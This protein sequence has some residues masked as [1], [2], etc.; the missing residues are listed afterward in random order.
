[1]ATKKAKLRYKI[2]G[3]AKEKYKNLIYETYIKSGFFRD[4]S[5]KIANGWTITTKNNGKI[6]VKLNFEDYTLESPFT[7]NE[8]NKN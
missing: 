6:E 1:L 3:Y 4:I 2:T 8:N 7:I 5:A